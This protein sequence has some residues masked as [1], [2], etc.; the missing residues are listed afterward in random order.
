MTCGL[1][2]LGTVLTF[3][4]NVF[5][6]SSWDS[7]KSLMARTTLYSDMELYDKENIPDDIFLK[8]QNFY[9]D[10]EMAVEVLQRS[11]LAAASF[12]RWL[13]AVYIYAD[14]CRNM[15]PKKNQLKQAEKL[16]TEVSYHS[17][18]ALLYSFL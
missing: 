12:A 4:R 9:Y 18:V 13:N 15:K 14:L 8:L 11:N 7:A 16:L 5:F 3:R 2:N 17:A 6:N 1:I 10:P